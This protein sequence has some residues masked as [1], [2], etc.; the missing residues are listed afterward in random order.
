MESNVAEKL[1]RVS[2]AEGSETT[3]EIKIKTLDSRTYTLK[4]DKQV[5]VPALK[6]QIA[7]V[8]GVL[9]EQQRLIC[10]GK[11]LKDDQLLSAYRILSYP[12]LT[13]EN[14][15]DGH[16][17]HMVVRQPI[18]PSADGSHPALMKM[19]KVVTVP[20]PKEWTTAQSC[21]VVLDVVYN[22]LGKMI[23]LSRLL[24]FY[25][26]H[27][28][29]LLQLVSV[30][31]TSHSHGN[32]VAPSVVI[33]TFNVPDQGDGVPP[34][35]SQIVSAVLGSF[36]FSNIGSGGSGIDVRELVSQRLERTSVASGT[37]D[38]AQQ[39]AELAGTRVQLNRPQSA[40]GIPT[41]VSLGPL[42][43][44]V[45][46]DSLTTLTQYLSHMRREFDGI[47]IGVGNNV[48]AGTEERDSS[49]TS[50]SGTVQEGLPTP[51]SLAE[52]MRSTRQMLI[53]QVGESLLQLAG[54]LD[55]QVNVNDPSLRMNTQSN[56]WRTGVILHNLGAFLLELGRTTMTL[57][58][59]QTPS[60][61][62]V[63]AGPAV[64]ISPTGP[65]PLM[66]LPFQP[67]TGFGAIPVGSVQPGS[68]LVNGRGAGFLPRRIDIQIRRGSSMATGNS[69]REESGNT[70][71]PS[72]QGN[73]PTG[74]A[75]EN[76]ANQTTSRNSEGSSFAGESGVRVVPIRTMVAAV[77]APFGRLPSD[78]SGNSVGLYYPVLGR[79][80]HVASGI[81]SGERGYQASAEHHSAGVQTEQLSVP[82]SAG[83]QTE[84][85]SVP[86]SAAQQH[87]TG[88][89]ARNGSLPNLQSRQEPAS[90]RSV[91]I[92]ILSAS[93]TQNN[94]ESERQIPSSVLQLLR[95][96]FPGGEIQVD[97]A[98][99]QGM[100]SGSVPELSATPVQDRGG[101]SSGPAEA[102]ASV[103]N[104]G[105]FLSNLL[106]QIM[107][108][109]SQ[110]SSAQQ[111]NSSTEQANTSEHTMAQDSSTHAESSNVGTSRR[112]SDSDPKT[113][114]S[115]R[116]KFSPNSDYSGY[117][118]RLS[119]KYALLLRIKDGVIYH[120]AENVNSCSLKAS[121]MILSDM[122]NEC[123]CSTGEMG[124]CHHS[125]N[126]VY[127][128][129]SVF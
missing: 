43:P 49:S 121:S 8:T 5:P 128:C 65:N 107:P 4:V 13:V 78:S 101:A 16:T 108:L 14:V 80:Q 116:Q 115:K 109:I 94:Q 112:Q 84:Q 111:N 79:F 118:N 75:S 91:N 98:G 76:L 69:N 85:V 77:P 19:E 55:N 23:A 20:E 46:P 89:P 39:Q 92:S 82:H 33:E 51:A 41:A 62:V 58:L 54:E 104:E 103:N 31:C 29:Y 81:V 99:L 117:I 87:N 45:I 63:N 50:Q 42:Q 83:V 72:G 120:M 22:V 73:S 96:L 93:G 25:A 70:Q 18:P 21:S 35:I 2:E 127:F 86:D 26:Y 27:K 44:P 10:R 37:S 12:Y 1:P 52:V 6:E 95:T 123:I 71:Q 67:G 74:P 102:E 106:H 47:G 28:S 100:A 88:D 113:P 97:D 119:S 64:F 56:A 59:G 53:E 90:A 48:Q 38:S 40:F 68:G 124:A 15:E 122:N 17:L 11:V 129:S 114:N 34:E 24:S 105:I 110:H 3:I 57:R 7:S 125:Q 32:Q 66:P 36:G 60:E 61:A 9:S 30:E 126:V